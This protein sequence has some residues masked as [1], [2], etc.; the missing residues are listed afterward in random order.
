M[1]QIFWKDGDFEAVGGI[2]L[3][4]D[5]FKFFKTLEEKG[6]KPV[7]IKVDDGWN[8]EILVENNEAYKNHLLNSK[9]GL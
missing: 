2:Y 7:G 5:I 8:L 1:E 3:R 9:K 6:I 4:N